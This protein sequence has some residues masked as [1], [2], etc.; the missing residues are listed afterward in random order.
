MCYHGEVMW[1]MSVA[2]QRIHGRPSS[3]VAQQQLNGAT[4]NKP[5]G[6]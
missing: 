2:R 6:L 4:N 5:T 3:T 1:Q